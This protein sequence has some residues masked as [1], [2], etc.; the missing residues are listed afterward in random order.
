MAN[1]IWWTDSIVECSNF[2]QIKTDQSTILTFFLFWEGKN[3]ETH[4]Y[5]FQVQL[6]IQS[7]NRTTLH[8]YWYISAGRNSLVTRQIIRKKKHLNALHHESGIALEH[9]MIFYQLSIVHHWNSWGRHFTISVSKFP[10]K[11]CIW[12]IGLPNPPM[13]T[14]FPYFLLREARSDQTK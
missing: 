6:H 13:E 4:F 3:T 2:Y 1:S 7:P 9:K 5:L 8:I 14:N 12:S 10:L 11:A